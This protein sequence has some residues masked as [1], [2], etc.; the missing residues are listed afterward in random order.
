MK[1]TAINIA[2]FIG[3]LAAM[4]GIQAIDDN[5]AEHEVA[6]EELAKQ[7]REERFATAAREICGQNAG[8]TVTQGN[9]LVCKTKRNKSTGQKVQL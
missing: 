3:I 9:V 2:L 5:S 6:R 4:V 8:W 1:H 7:N